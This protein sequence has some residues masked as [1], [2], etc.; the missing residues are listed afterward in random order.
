M[1]VCQWRLDWFS[2]KNIY[3]YI[4]ISGFFRKPEKNSGLTPGQNDDPVI[5]WPW[6]ERWP[7][8]PTD[9]VIQWPSSMPG[10]D[11]NSWYFAIS[12]PIVPFLIRI[13]ARS[14]RCRHDSR[15]PVVREFVRRSRP[16]VAQKRLNRSME[17]TSGNSRG[18]LFD[19]RQ[20]RV[21]STN[22]VLRRAVHWH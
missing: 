22:H 14:A 18:V 3:I 16:R 10:L 15:R 4:F 1:S 13:A 21:G 11:T 8:R 2:Q 19:G 17:T 9:P 7:K 12:M 6:R 5:R 20:T